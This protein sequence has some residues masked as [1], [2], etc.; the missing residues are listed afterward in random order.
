M[1]KGEKMIKNNKRLIWKGI[2]IK[3]LLL[4]ITDYKTIKELQEF[5]ETKWIDIECLKNKFPKI[6]NQIV[7]Q[8]KK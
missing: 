3:K 7:E 5:Y 6:Y 2:E 8:V 4:S 1:K